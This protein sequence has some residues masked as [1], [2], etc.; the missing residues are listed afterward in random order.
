[1]TKEKK[2]YE[3]PSLA[4]VEFKTERGYAISIATLD[5]DHHWF[6]YESSNPS[7]TQYSE[8][9]SWAGYDWN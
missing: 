8:D 9:N 4:T 6:E 7:V 1:M 5:L 2:Q 3:A